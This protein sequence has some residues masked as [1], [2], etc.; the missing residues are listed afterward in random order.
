MWILD[1]ICIL[2][3]INADYSRWNGTHDEEIP[4]IGTQTMHICPLKIKRIYIWYTYMNDWPIPTNWCQSSAIYHI[5]NVNILIAKWNFFHFK[6]GVSQFAQLT[7]HIK[8][9][10]RTRI[11]ACAKYYSIKRLTRPKRFA[12]WKFPPRIRVISPIRRYTVALVHTFIL[13]SS[14]RVGQFLFLFLF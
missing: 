5:L 6:L 12:K 7:D 1:E 2:F 13:A 14:L 3:A 9:A 11:I 8:T 10:C 4:S